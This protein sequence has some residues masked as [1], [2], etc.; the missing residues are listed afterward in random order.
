MDAQGARQIEV[1]AMDWRVFAARLIEQPRQS[2]PLIQ[3]DGAFRLDDVSL[4]TK[5]EKLRL[6]P[7]PHSCGACGACGATASQ[8]GFR[9]PTLYCCW[10]D[11]WDK[12]LRA[13]PA[14]HSVSTGGATEAASILSV[15]HAP[16][17]PPNEIEHLIF[18]R[19]FRH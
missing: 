13:P 11:W 17:V 9:R 19:F 6:Q 15:P 14:P 5:S 12:I 10:W 7:D 18:V 3:R 16:H 1:D 8:K 2:P 4:Y